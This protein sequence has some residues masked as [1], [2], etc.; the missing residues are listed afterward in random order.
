MVNEAQTTAFPESEIR[1]PGKPANIAPDLRNLPLV[2]PW[3]LRHH[4]QNVRE[5][6]DRNLGAIQASLQEY[7]Q[8]TPLVVQRSTG[9]VCKGNGTLQVIRDFLKWDKVAV[10]Y[11]DFD[12]DQ[13]EAYAIA[14]NH[15]SD[16][17]NWNKRLV[18]KLRGFEGRGLI[19]MTAFDPDEFDDV[20]AQMGA[21]TITNPEEFRGGYA[22]TPEELAERAERIAGHQTGL[23]EVVLALKAEDYEAFVLNVAKLQRAYG[24]SGVI[25]TVV[26]AMKRA[27]AQVAS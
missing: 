26:E 8:Q 16:L 10:S 19:Q 5:H 27:A 24:T 18:E 17:A 12:N 21:V 11:E 6:N 23:K 2:D 20:V 9:Y 14:D 4:P 3:E 7:G 13:A 15:A 22:E 1:A 25:A